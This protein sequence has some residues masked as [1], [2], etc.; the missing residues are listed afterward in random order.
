MGISG[1]S[2]GQCS[3]SHLGKVHAFHMLVMAGVF[4]VQADQTQI[5][6]GRHDKA[7]GVDGFT[8]MQGM[9]AAGCEFLTTS[10]EGINPITNS[11]IPTEHASTRVGDDAQVQGLV[12]V[13]AYGVGQCGPA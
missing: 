5:T 13:T 11:P 4:G 7:P 3:Q 8:G 1:V 2:F 9:E 6:Q 12:R 10:H